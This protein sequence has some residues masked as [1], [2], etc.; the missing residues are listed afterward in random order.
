VDHKRRRRAWDQGFSVKSLATYQ[1][2]IKDC[3][4]QLTTQL[5]NS[6]GKAMDATAWTMMLAFDVMGEVAFGKDFGGLR[7]GKEPAAARA[8][9]DHMT[10][11]GTLGMVPWLLWLLQFIP[12]ATQG[13]APFIKWCA[14]QVQGQKKKYVPDEKTPRNL[15]GWL[16]KAFVEGDASAPPTEDALNDD[17]RLMIIAGR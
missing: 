3:V 6:G 14:E 16:I 2:R 5:G 4:D 7:T 15:S 13:Y 12:G 9:H 17:A 10:V 8:V 11:L 1:P